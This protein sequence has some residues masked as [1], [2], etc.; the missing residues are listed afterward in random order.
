M[1]TVYFISDLHLGAYNIADEQEKEKRLLSWLRKI[2][3]EQAELIIVGD[4]FDFW[5]EYKHVI[6]R[7]HIRVLAQLQSLCQASPVHYVAGNHDFWL[8]SFMRE[9]IGLIIHAEEY[10]F[11]LD[12]YKVYIKH[13]DGLLRNDY[14]Y[15]FLKRILRNKMN[16]FLYRMLHPDIGVPFALFC[17][18]LSRRSGEKSR[19]EYMDIDYR[20]FAMEKIEQ[21][22]QFVV[23]GHT[24][25]AALEKHGDGHYINPGYWGKDF[26]YAVIRE[27]RVEL[28]WWDGENEH[29]YIP[30]Y[31]PGNLKQNDGGAC[32][33]CFI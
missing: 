12:Q 19:H 30:D 11:L 8:D 25:W 20:K 4:L 29:P 27:G 31:P 23:L 10:V 33:S 3:T 14:G 17:S 13:G 24:H 32:V 18:H 26:T 7:K 2:E 28:H 15:R 5:F 16:I 21:G 9:D 6:L 22:F 1:R